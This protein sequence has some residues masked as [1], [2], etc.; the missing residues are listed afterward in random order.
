MI[1][2]G[3]RPGDLDTMDVAEIESWRSVMRVYAGAI[4]RYR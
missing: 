3:F 4:G 1:T 2:M